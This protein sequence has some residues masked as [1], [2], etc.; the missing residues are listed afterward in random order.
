MAE[1]DESEMS[2]RQGM[3]P[4]RRVRDRAGLL[5]LSADDERN[6]I[7]ATDPNSRADPDPDPIGD[8][9]SSTLS[10][11]P[12]ACSGRP[13]GASPGRVTHPTHQAA[14]RPRARMRPHPQA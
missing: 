12:L 10:T 7:T 8:P 14:S 9:D 1:N 5:R 3:A 2:R 13:G 11:A 4:S 6:A